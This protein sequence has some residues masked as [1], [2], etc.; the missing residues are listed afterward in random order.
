MLTEPARCVGRSFA[1]RREQA[2]RRGQTIGL[3]EILVGSALLLRRVTVAIWPREILRGSY[4][5]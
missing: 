4:F 5:R 3:L 1:Q 2:H